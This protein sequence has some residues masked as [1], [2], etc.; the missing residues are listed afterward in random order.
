M[1]APEFV[2]FGALPPGVMSS[3]A[4]VT[5]VWYAVGRAQMESVEKAARRC[6]VTTGTPQVVHAHAPD[7]SCI[8]GGG[9]F[10]LRMGGSS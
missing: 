1:T 4:G 2:V 7:G 5:D 6:V 10:L 3:F 9:C 8:R